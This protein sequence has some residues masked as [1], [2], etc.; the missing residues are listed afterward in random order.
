MSQRTENSEFSSFWGHGRTNEK[1]SYNSE[2]IAAPSRYNQNIGQSRMEPGRLNIFQANEKTVFPF[3]NGVGE[4]EPI[5]P[6]PHAMMGYTD[7]ETGRPPVFEMDNGN[8]NGGRNLGGNGGNDA[9][10]Y[11]DRSPGGTATSFSLFPRIRRDSLGREIVP[12]DF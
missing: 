9:G 10:R 5:S 3:G 6:L 1:N 11:E 2:P 4:L 7:E 8:G 12:K